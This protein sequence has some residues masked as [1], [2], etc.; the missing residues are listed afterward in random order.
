MIRVHKIT[1]GPLETNCYVVFEKKTKEAV[2]IDPGDESK[3]ILDVIKNGDLK[4]KA[5][6]LTHRHPDHIGALEEVGDYLGIS[7]ARPL[8]W[9]EAVKTPGHT[10]DSVCFVNK[11]AGVVFSG[12]TLFKNGIGRTDLSG[13]DFN[14]IQ[15]SLQCLMQFPDHFKIHPGHGP[16]STIGE[17]KQNNS[18]LV[19]FA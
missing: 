11:E 7:L 3:K 15:K 5:I 14:Q 9:L 6:L 8:E 2:I 1:V 18:F 10:P 16:D 17:E 4:P 13:G 12:D 19:K